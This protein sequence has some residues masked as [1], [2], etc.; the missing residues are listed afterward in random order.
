MNNREWTQ[1]SEYLESKGEDLRCLG[2]GEPLH[3]QRKGKFVGKKPKTLEAIFNPEEGQEGTGTKQGT[4][5]G[6]MEN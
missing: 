1:K 6:E 5:P 3:E 2:G 4:H